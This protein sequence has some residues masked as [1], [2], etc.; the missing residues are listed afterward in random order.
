[1]LQCE[2]ISIALTDPRE[3]SVC[4]YHKETQELKVVSLLTG[5]GSM[6]CHTFIFSCNCN[7]E[8]HTFRWTCSALLSR[9]RRWAE[10]M[11]H[12]N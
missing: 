5:R 6:V 11:N 4:H 12:F 9:A 1:M 7:R 2:E 3:S 8:V 10:Q